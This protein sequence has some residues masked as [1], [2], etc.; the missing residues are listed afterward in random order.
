MAQLLVLALPPTPARLRAAL[1]TL[2]S[3][4]RLVPSNRFS[5]HGASQRLMRQGQ[6]DALQRDLWLLIAHGYA[7]QD[8]DSVYELTPCGRRYVSNDSDDTEDSPSMITTVSSP[9]QE[10]VRHLECQ[11]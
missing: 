2:D 6:S 4:L 5:L 7:R 8:A 1:R 11:C 9:A 10:H 3:I